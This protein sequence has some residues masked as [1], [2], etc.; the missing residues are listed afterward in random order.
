LLYKITVQVEDAGGLKSPFVSVYINVIDDNE[1]RPVF[2]QSNYYWS[3]NET[4]VSGSF[5][6]VHAVD[7]DR[8]AMI[9]YSFKEP[10]TLLSITTISGAP[11]FSFQA[12]PFDYERQKEYAIQIVASDGEKRDEATLRIVITNEND[13]DP[14]FTHSEQQLEVYIIH[15]VN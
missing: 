1:H 15:S 7:A 2:T 14:R 11:I 9:T 4:E 13:N 8:D 5:A 3:V 10:Q 6:G 12:R